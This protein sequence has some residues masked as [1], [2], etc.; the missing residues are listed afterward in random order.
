MRTAI[1]RT[2][3][4]AVLLSVPVAGCV[5]TTGSNPAA[6]PATATATATV[7]AVATATADATATATAAQ[8]TTT[9]GHVDRRNLKPS[10]TPDWGKRLASSSATP[11]STTPPA[12]SSSATPVTTTGAPPPPDGTS[13]PQPLKW[14]GTA[15]VYELPPG[16][17]PPLPCPAGQTWKNN[18]CE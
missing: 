13:C 18:K 8:P 3:I 1:R 7:T 6:T 2:F 5:V 16:G 10:R 9:A 11:A 15:C 4:A 17:R 12:T 14:N